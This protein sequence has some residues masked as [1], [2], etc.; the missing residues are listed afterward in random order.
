MNKVILIELRFFCTSVLWGSL[1]LVIYDILRILRRIIIHNSFFVAF[2]DLIYWV[3]S[4]LLIFRMLYQQNDGIIRGFA[5]MAMV[6]GMILY[7]ATLSDWLVDT[8]SAIIHKV[9]AFVKKIIGIILFPVKWIIHR[10]NR[11]FIWLL[12]K[13][14]KFTYFLLKILKKMPKSSKMAVA[15]NDAENKEENN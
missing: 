13:I 6:L 15:E 14:K 4:S 2:E 3:I 8:I 11:I 9:I 10:I 12:G 1:L 5:I 7:H